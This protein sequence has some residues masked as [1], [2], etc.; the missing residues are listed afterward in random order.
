MYCCTSAVLQGYRRGMYYPRYL[1][2]TPGMCV[3]LRGTCVCIVYAYFSADRH[4]HTL[5]KCTHA[6]VYIFLLRT[7][8]PLICMCLYTNCPLLCVI[9]YDIRM[10]HTCDAMLQKYCTVLQY[11]LFETFLSNFIH[12]KENQYEYYT[13]S[14]LHHE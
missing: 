3:Y 6:F 4:V 7:C 11:T 1:W 9:I 14:L 2:I 12:S 10:T 13:S 5:R 8:K